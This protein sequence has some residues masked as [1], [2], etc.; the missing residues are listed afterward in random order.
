MEYS[1][2]NLKRS[3]AVLTV[4]YGLARSDYAHYLQQSEDSIA[5]SKSKKEWRVQEM[6]LLLK[7][8][9]HFESMRTDCER[10]QCEWNAR[11]QRVIMR[12]GYEEG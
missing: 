2:W 3:S 11:A 9:S 1:H 5:E 10:G 4:L 8:R 12:I 6:D 7:D